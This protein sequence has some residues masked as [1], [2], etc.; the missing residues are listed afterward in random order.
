MTTLLHE[1]APLGRFSLP[2]QRYAHR[3]GLLPYAP[4]F[5][6]LRPDE[7][8]ALLSRLYAA[9]DSSDL[10]VDDALFVREAAMEIANGA[11]ERELPGSTGD[12]GR[13]R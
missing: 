11:A 4:S 9:Y 10:S 1:L 13:H 7:Q 12:F 5:R 2:T 8:D 6:S 3:L